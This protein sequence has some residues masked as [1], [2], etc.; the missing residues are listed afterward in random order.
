MA[1]H[2][3]SGGEEEDTI[4][5]IGTSRKECVEFMKTIKLFSS[6]A[7]LLLGSAIGD[8][9]WAFDDARHH[10]GD[11]YYGGRYGFGHGRF[12]LSPYYAYHPRKTEVPREPPVYIQRQN[13]ELSATGPQS[14]YWHYCSNPEGYYPHVK[15]CPVGWLPVAP[16]PMETKE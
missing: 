13:I 8:S 12:L 1:I 7:I 16:Q 9:V 14:G 5:H 15:K 6:L 4:G 11:G 2:F 3:S 10:F